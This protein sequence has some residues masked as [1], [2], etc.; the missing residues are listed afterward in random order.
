MYLFVQC[1]DY[2]Y[3]NKQEKMQPK[4][5]EEEEDDDDDMNR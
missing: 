4:K 5:E 2:E 3:L 1:M